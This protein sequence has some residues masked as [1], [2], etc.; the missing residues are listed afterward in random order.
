MWKQFIGKLSWKSM[1]SS[2]GGGGGGSP[3]AKPP[4]L[5]LRENGAAGKPNVSPPSAAG[6][7][8]AEVRSREDAFVQKVNICCV[9]FDFSDRGKDS[10]EK[11]RKR[12]MLMSLVDCIGAAEEPLTEVMI[13]ACVRMFA[14]N[15]FRVFPPK[16]RSGT[17]ASET[18][19]DEPFFDPS[20]YHLQV[21][22]EFLLRFVTSPF[23]DPKVARKYVDSTF[24]SRL[25]DLFDSDDPRERDCLKTILHRIY[26]KFMGNRPFIRKA[27]SNI[28]YRFVFE[29]DH[30]N[31]IAE[32][33]EVFGSV[34]SG[35]AKPLKEEHKL[36]LW[37][38]LIPLHKPKTVGVYLP[39]LTYCITQFI[40]KEPKLAGTVIRGLLKYW[41][42]TNS[43]KEMMFLGELEEVLELTDMAEFQKCIVPLFRRIAN[44]LNSSHF[45]VAERALFLWNNEHL[46]DMISQ[47]RQ[48]ILPLIYPA[49]E[50]NTRWHWNQSVLN[51]T[52]N[53]R[54]MFLDMD[55][56]LLLACQSNFQEEEEKRAATAE[57]RRLMWEQLERN[58][59]HGYQPV[60]ADASFPAPHSL[61][62]LVAPTVT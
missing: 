13:S 36:F 24:V 62:R 5:S 43:Q 29:A 46:F 15:L 8:G 23:V 39:Q 31:G 42:V 2:S 16:V 37:K 18:E 20:W 48:V 40:E 35:F 6:G 50:R 49:L 28:F 44:C 45:Q 60:I 25:L 7:A 55:E 11:E 32:L 9:V 26:G 41:P 57:R 51:V 14:V 21:V 53:V 17:A 1:K 12:Q 22:Y 58:A 38:A 47:N 27:V 34:I 56:K 52:M 4:P 19:E 59:A 33:L 30:H 61:G 3:P 54:K 10:P